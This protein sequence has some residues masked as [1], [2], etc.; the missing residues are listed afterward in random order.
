[1][2][3]VVSETPEATS[4]TGLSEPRI[5]LQVEFE[6]D[7][8]PLVLEIG[9]RRELA[10]VARTPSR[11]EI[12]L[13]DSDL[14]ADLERAPTEFISKKLFDGPT[15]ELTHLRVDERSFEKRASGTEESWQETSPANEELSAAAVPDFLFELSA[16]SAER[17]LLEA[18]ELG[19]PAHTIGLAWSEPE[20]EDTLSIWTP[21]GERVYARRQ[22]D[23]VVLEL[24]SEAW[25]K[26]ESLLRLGPEDDATP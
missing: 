8:A 6:G 23:D 25:A 18:P 12:F 2:K 7:T 11:P 24:T 16:T 15:F 14:A 22:G 5:T 19:A 1:M 4:D 9:D 17:V 3:E 21:P 20:R 26:V 13:I 10:T